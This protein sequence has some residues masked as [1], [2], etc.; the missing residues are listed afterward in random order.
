[1]W[2]TVGFRGVPMGFAGVA[3]DCRNGVGELP[4]RDVGTAADVDVVRS[5]VVLE[6]VQ[7]SVSQVVGV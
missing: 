6:Q 1:M 3:D 2:S 7:T 4:D 5:V